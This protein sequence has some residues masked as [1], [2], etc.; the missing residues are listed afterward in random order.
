ME[1]LFGKEETVI[2]FSNQSPVEVV[3]SELQRIPDGL[4]TSKS[5]PQNTR[6]SAVY[7]THFLQPWR[8][9]ESNTRLYHNPWATYQY[10]SFFT[11]FPQAIPGSENYTYTGGKT[12]A[13]LLRP[14][15]DN[16]LPG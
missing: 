5:G 8:L 13:E 7:V 9:D 1:A 4:W 14:G 10:Q 2:Y 6:V 11:Q 15:L 12:F 16:F 3:G